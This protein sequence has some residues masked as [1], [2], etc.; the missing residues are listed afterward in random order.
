MK[1]RSILDIWNQI[2]RELTEEFR[3]FTM[4]DVRLDNI[5]NLRRTGTVV[6]EEKEENGIITRTLVYEA[7]DGSVKI[8]RIISETK[9]ITDVAELEK[10]K[11]EAIDNSN[12]EDAA[13]YRDM[14]AKLNKQNK[15]QLA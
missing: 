7:N 10:L 3:N 9:N 2:D 14:I 6:E 12:F 4:P 8:N 1:S 15:K 13:K 11:Q 5:E